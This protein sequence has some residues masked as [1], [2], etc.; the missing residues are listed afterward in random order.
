MAPRTN[1][2][3]PIN[4]MKHKEILEASKKISKPYRITDGVRDFTAGNRNS[5]FITEEEGSLWG[6]GNNAVGQLGGGSEPQVRLRPVRVA[7]SVHAASASASHR[8]AEPGLVRERVARFDAL[9]LV[10]TILTRP[11]G[12]LHALRTRLGAP[13]RA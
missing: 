11:A 10:V 2:F 8:S 13:R 6:M 3:Q 7:S 4:P 1:T 12:W 9:P 5:L